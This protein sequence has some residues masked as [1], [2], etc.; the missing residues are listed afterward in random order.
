MKPKIKKLQFKKDYIF[1]IQFHDGRVGDIDFKP[2]LW[3]EAFELLKNSTYFQRAF[4]DKTT[5][6]ITW[7]NGADIA[8]ETLYQ[9][10]AKTSKTVQL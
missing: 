7:P 9:K 6:T 8:P 5:G 3:G 10:L 1:H 2:Y 4:I